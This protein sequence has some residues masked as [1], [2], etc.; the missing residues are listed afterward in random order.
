MKCATLLLSLLLFSATVDGQ[1]LD[2]SGY[3]ALR[4]ING[5]GPASWLEEG[6][7]RLPAGGDENEG[8]AV[9]QLG[10]TWQPVRW[11]DVHVSGAARQ[12][13]EDARGTAAGFVEA[14]ADLRAVFTRDQIQLRAGQFFLPTSRENR[15]ELWTSPYSIN[16][17]ALNSWIGE[18][19]R[20]IGVDLEWRHEFGVN[21]LTTGATVFRGNDT[22]GTLLAWRGW[23]I[24]NRLTVYDEV[25]PLSA[26]S[27][28]RLFPRQQ[29]GTTPFRE[30]LDGKTGFAARARWSM[31]ERGMIQVAHVDNQ[32]DR[33]LWGDEYS[34]IT[35]FSV[36]SAEV[37]RTDS[38]TAAAEYLDGDTG[39]GFRGSP[40]VQMDFYAAYLLLSQKYGRNRWT[41][42]YDQFDNT[43]KDFSRAENNSE[44]GRAW[45]F[46]WL[47]DVTA[48]TRL[49]L[50]FTQVTG[51]RVAL[52]D[53]PSFDG[54]NVTV[55]LR[56]SF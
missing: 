21:A 54:R 26:E 50:E 27:L 41:A 51:E 2:V 31:P 37:G 23:T 6:N 17:S 47:F 45:T 18:E 10:V 12:E 8:A 55:E 28:P 52:G 5:S 24:G 1:T 42:R 35:R 38:F 15:G 16:F 14:Y 40:W 39:M 53:A 34:W 4:G 25:L 32:G 7:G 13:P 36:I 46:A 44:D 29:D 11:F 22:M 49:G 48:K 43:E 19:F 20:P 33:R 3:V 9:A 56:Y 30:D